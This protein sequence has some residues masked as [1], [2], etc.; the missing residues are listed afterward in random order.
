[1]KRRH[2]CF[3]RCCRHD[4]MGT[5]GIDCSAGFRSPQQVVALVLSGE[6][7]LLYTLSVDFDWRYLGAIVQVSLSVKLSWQSSAGGRKFSMKCN[8]NKKAPIV[9]LII[10]RMSDRLQSIEHYSSCHQGWMEPQR[11]CIMS[12]KTSR[13][14]KG[15]RFGFDRQSD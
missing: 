8:N 2:G 3:A 14:P 7:F 1:M 6:H 13:K 10:T 5:T 9:V 15:K 11:A 4:C 12:D